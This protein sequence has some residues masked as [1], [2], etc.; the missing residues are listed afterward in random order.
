MSAGN[1][2]TIRMY[3]T[4]TLVQYYQRESRKT[5][6]DPHSFVESP[7]GPFIDPAVGPRSVG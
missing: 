2:E 7:V 3:T 5:A 1:A 4:P 6:T